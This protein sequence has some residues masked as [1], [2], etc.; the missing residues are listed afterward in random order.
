MS[1]RAS[2]RNNEPFRTWNRFHKP[3]GFNLEFEPPA[4]LFSRR[5]A[6]APAAPDSLAAGCWLLAAGCWLLA[7]GCWLLAA[8]CWLLFAAGRSRP[9]KPQKAG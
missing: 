7:A 2:V 8:G 9:Q 1:S 6:S 3:G 4:A 5:G